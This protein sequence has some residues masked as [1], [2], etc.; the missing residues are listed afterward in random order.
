MF[1]VAKISRAITDQSLQSSLFDVLTRHVPV[2]WEESA[3]TRLKVSVVCTRS[4]VLNPILDSIVNCDLLVTGSQ[5]RYCQ[6]GLL[7]SWQENP[8]I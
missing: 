8:A 1:V 2:E 5:P 7:R 6:T 3:G 4:E